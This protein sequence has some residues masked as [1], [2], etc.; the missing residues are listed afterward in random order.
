MLRTL[1]FSS[2]LLQGKQ[3]RWK[4]RFE[5]AGLSLT[6]LFGSSSFPSATTSPLNSWHSQDA[7]DNPW[8]FIRKHFNFLSFSSV[9]F[10]CSAFK[11]RK[12]E[13]LTEKENWE[14]V[15]YSLVEIYSSPQKILRQPAIKSH[16]AK[17]VSSYGIY[18]KRKLQSSLNSFRY[19]DNKRSVRWMS[20]SFPIFTAR[21]NLFLFFPFSMLL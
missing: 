20:S 15:H 13:K 19:I 17:N 2:I 8:Y 9:R 4:A 1:P 21:C 3:P 12:Y 11:M 18:R 6:P 14:I 5:A 10:G 16:V 7:I